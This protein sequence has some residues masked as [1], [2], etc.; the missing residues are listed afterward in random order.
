MQLEGRSVRAVGRLE[1]QAATL[2]ACCKRR[3]AW[4]RQIKLLCLRVDSLSCAFEGLFVMAMH[5]LCHDRST[6][7]PTRGFT[8][9]TSIET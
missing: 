2:I 5:L 7:T 3:C 1:C 6:P 9:K 8:S 4:I